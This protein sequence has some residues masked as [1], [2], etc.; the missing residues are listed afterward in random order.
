MKERKKQAQCGIFCKISKKAP[1]LASRRIPMIYQEKKTVKQN[2][3]ETSQLGRLGSGFCQLN[4][5]LWLR[6]WEGCRH[7]ALGT[8]PEETARLTGRLSLWKLLIKCTDLFQNKHPGLKPVSNVFFITFWLFTVIKNYEDISHISQRHI[9]LNSNK[10]SWSL[11]ALMRDF[12]TSV[13]IMSH[14]IIHSRKRLKMSPALHT[15]G[16]Q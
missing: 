11:T 5:G 2:K 4:P 1:R 12:K 14:L 8:S 16:T 7:S 15:V 9:L 3:T 6:G 13:I 10:V